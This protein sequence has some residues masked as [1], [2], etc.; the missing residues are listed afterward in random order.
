MGKRVELV[1]DDE[2][3]AALESLQSK[4][5]A[6]SIADVLRAA[7]GVYNSLQDMLSRGDG[8]R[9]ALLDRG[10]GEFTELA[11]P[12]LQLQPAVEPAAMAV[13]TG[14]VLHLVPKDDDHG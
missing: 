9:L 14:R 12:S 11:I 2:A 13:K 4:T 1:L 7:L 8:K 10:A 6:G 5:R 3:L